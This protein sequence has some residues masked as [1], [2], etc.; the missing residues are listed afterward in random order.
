MKIEDQG[1]PFEI[2]FNIGILNYLQ[3]KQL[4]P[5]WVDYYRQELTN[6]NFCE[7]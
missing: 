2:G 5:E 4:S 7:I 3:Q 6:L 1:R